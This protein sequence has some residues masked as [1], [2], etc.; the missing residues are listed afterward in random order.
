MNRNYSE[1]FKDLILAYKNGVF[2]TKINELL[3]NENEDKEKLC[4]QLSSLCGVDLGYSED[5]AEKLKE[6]IKKY[7]GK[8]KIVIKINSTCESCAQ[9]EGACEASCPFDAILMNEEN[10]GRYIDVERCTDCGKCVD[11][12]KS[13]NIVDKVQFLPLFELIN[14][15]KPVIAAVA[16]AIANQFNGA[17]LNKMRTAFKNIGFTDMVE[18]A[19]FADMLT[20]KEA[21]EFD[22]MVKN[23]DDFMIT[24]CCCPM[25]VAMI[26]KVYGDL[27][28]HVSPSVSP[29]IAAGRVMKKL[30]PDVKV[31]FVGPCI[32]KKSE[33]KEPDLLGD[34]DFVL[35]FQ[36]VQEIFDAL[37][38]D[39]SKLSE[40]PTIEYASR[41]GRL[42]ARTGGVSIAI[43]EAV[44]LLFP[45]K[46]ENLTEVQ[47]NGVKECKAL[48]NKV[49]SGEI[50]GNFIEGMGCVGGCVGGPKAILKMEEGTKM[51][52]EC[53]ENAEFKVAT[54]SE[55]MQ[56]IL[57]D[58]DIKVLKDFLNH[59]KTNIFHRSFNK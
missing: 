58:L 30:N 31:V 26:K 19:F 29:M 20:L 46:Y 32:A 28:K 36:E 59:D 23:E 50:Q 49:I 18:V 39:P 34:I 24:S 48:L 9:G 57:K 11:A 12:C 33:A 5:F 53:A 10:T 55:K 47:G 43:K 14:S 42:Y 37:D 15:D 52:N 54:Q 25:W 40:T 8:E 6:G 2:E 17:N 56:E 4:R 44:E 22:A 16:P 3:E 7:T 38:V 35:T 41:G 45:N 21:V 27:I 13:G 1:Y 51:V